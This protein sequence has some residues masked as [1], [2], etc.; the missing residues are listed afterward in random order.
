[1]LARCRPPSGR[2]AV[3]R[4]VVM[5]FGSS[6]ALGPLTGFPEE[7][8]QLRLHLDRQRAGREN[9]VE[10]GMQLDVATI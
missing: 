8:R 3:L 4:L 10:Q 2:L 9:L 6:V 1:M 5:R 7:N